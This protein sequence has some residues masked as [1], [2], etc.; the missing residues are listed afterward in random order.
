[1]L[2]KILVEIIAKRGV[3]VLDEID[4]PLDDA[5]CRRFLKIIDKFSEQTQFVTITHNKI[6]MDT[7]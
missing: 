7:F 5:N 1:M 2:D 6:T 3:S 4:A